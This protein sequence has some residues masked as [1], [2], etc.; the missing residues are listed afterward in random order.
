MLATK[1]QE[2]IALHAEHFS[3]IYKYIAYRINDRDR[4]EELANDVFRIVWEKQPEEPP[5]L[6]W[7]IA[8]ARNVLGNEYK[9]RRRREQL[10]ERLAEEARINGT[11]GDQSQQDNVADI[12]ARLKDKDREILMLAYWDDLTTAELAES[13]GCSPSAAAVRLHR[14]RKAFAKA[15]P[16]QLMT[17]REV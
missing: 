3:R 13:L 2:L 12:L 5:G 14:A 11:D 16:Q 1:E 15:A 17:E 8:T 10:M 7:L 9:G 6:G 4:A